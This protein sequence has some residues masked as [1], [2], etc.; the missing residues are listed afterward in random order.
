MYL[1]FCRC[2]TQSFNDFG[3]YPDQV[4]ELEDHQ[5]GYNAATG[6]FCDM[7]KSGIIDPLKVRIKL[8]P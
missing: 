6:E 2:P 5:Q 4:L 1:L 3:S 8:P 7:V